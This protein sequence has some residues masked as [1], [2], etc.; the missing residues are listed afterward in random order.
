MNTEMLRQCLLSQ[1][2]SFTVGWISEKKARLGACIDLKH[3]PEGLWCVRTLGNVLPADY[4]HDRANDYRNTRKA[5][6]I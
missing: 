2:N 4:L 3:G 5:S 6:D 1:G